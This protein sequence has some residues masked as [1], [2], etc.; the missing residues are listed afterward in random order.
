MLSHQHQYISCDIWDTISTSMS[1]NTCLLGYE[2]SDYHL[3]WRV[4]VL[5]HSCSN[6]RGK[7]KLAFIIPSDYLKKSKRDIVF[8]STMC[9]K[10]C[11]HVHHNLQLNATHLINMQQKCLLILITEKNYR[12]FNPFIEN[13]NNE[14]SIWKFKSHYSISEHETRVWITLSQVLNMISNFVG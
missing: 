4:S 7:T 10:I 12:K 1:Q 13:L 6:Y 9:L 5:F 11:T 8:N 2:R 3:I 14:I